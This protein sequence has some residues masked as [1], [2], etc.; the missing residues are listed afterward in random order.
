MNFHADF[1]A[2]THSAHD[3]LL[4]V[5]KLLGYALDPEDMVDMLLA[6]ARGVPAS[7]YAESIRSHVWA[8]FSAPLLALFA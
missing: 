5:E 6:H 1:T 3:Y 8:T 7:D 4:Q 2:R